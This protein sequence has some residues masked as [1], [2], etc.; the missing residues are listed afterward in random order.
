MK[1]YKYPR[2]FHLPW[3]LGI[4]SDDKVVEHLCGFEGR[5]VVITEK[6]DGE[7]TTMY[8][9]A[10]HARS[11]DGQHHPSRD[12]VKNFWN[13]I[14]HNIPDDF[15][16]CGEN[17]YAKHSIEYTDLDSFFYGFSIWEH[18]QCL[19]WSDTK[20]I[21]D[22]IG[23]ACVPELYVGRFDSNM[24]RDLL[25]SQDFYGRYHDGK[26]EGYVVRVASSFS[27]DQFATSVA[28]FVRAN[29]VQTNKHWM[30]GPVIPNQLKK[31]K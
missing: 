21:F 12:W 29:H 8:N 25:F 31:E 16:I 14:R 10:I 3:S 28:K 30:K 13:S 6:L 26:A 7:N 9:D 2:T 22:E 11:I 20:I 15:R 4:T 19:S 27:V 23:I 18:D 1:L 24:I 17:V 5:D